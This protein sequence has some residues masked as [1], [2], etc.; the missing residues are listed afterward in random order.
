MTSMNVS[1]IAILNTKSTDYCSI[2]SG[3]SISEAINLKNI[4][5]ARKAEYY[6]K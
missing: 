4:N 6:N 3:I 5:L 1:Y 2:I